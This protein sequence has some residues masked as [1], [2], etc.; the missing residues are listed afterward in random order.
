MT[1]AIN[2][3]SSRIALLSITVWVL[4]IALLPLV[5]W[6]AKRTRDNTPRLPEAEGEHTGVISGD[7]APLRVLII[8]ESTVVG[9]GVD[10]IEQGLV[11]HFVHAF[12]LATG[13]PLIW[14]LLGQNGATVA[15]LHARLAAAQVPDFDL[16]VLAVGVNDAKALHSPRRWRRDLGRLIDDLHRR[17]PTAAIYLSA[18]PPLGLFPALPQ[19]LRFLLGLQASRLSL[20]SQQLLGSLPFAHHVQP[21]IG[22][23]P[24]LFASD[25]FHPSA[26][27]YERW[28]HDLVAAI[29][30]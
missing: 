6:Q 26:L 21:D 27:G 29:T 28:A 23:D 24:A 19:P 18:M 2:C 11:G 30:R 5:L 8:G 20:V 10:R 1:D 16:V 25:G 4:L 22:F 17:R 9:V 13:R 7:G 3:R 12:A 14:E 15:E